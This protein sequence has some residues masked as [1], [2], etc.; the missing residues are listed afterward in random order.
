MRS[1]KLNMF[2]FDLG[3]LERIVAKCY[4]SYYNTG[5]PI[6]ENHVYFSWLF[7]LF[8]ESAVR[9]ERWSHFVFTPNK[10][11]FI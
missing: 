6:K 5:K 1:V 3:I 2:I 7:L 9:Y 4:L 11:Q 10:E 8:K